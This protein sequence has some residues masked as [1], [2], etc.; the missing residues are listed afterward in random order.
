MVEA[1]L[2]LNANLVLGALYLE[3]VSSNTL[4]CYKYHREKF[5]WNTGTA[6]SLE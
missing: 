3:R 6:L 5:P 2:R 4:S 1:G